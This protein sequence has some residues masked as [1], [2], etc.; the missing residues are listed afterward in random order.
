MKYC[1]KCGA[2]LIETKRL[3]GYSVMS[4][5]K[6]YHVWVK[7]P[8][9]KRRLFFGNGHASGRLVSQFDMDMDIPKVVE[10]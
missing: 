10:E 8:N 6:Q 5:R 4:G 1:P 9:Y 7:C 2:R 3:I